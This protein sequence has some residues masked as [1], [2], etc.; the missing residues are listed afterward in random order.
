[1]A[2]FFKL[3]IGKLQINFAILFNVR[4]FFCYKSIFLIL[5]YLPHELIGQK[6]SDF[7]NKDDFEIAR[8]AVIKGKHKSKLDDCF[9]LIVIYLLATK[10]KEKIKSEPY[11]FRHK[12]GE[13][14]Y[15]ETHLSVFENPFNNKI[16]YV[17]LKCKLLSQNQE[18]IEQEQISNTEK[19]HNSSFV[20]TS[21][22]FDL[23]QAT[24]STDYSHDASASMDPFMMTDNNSKS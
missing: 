22:E 16:E 8:G 11:R 13:Y 2:L 19:A 6:I 9:F 20:F 17:I 21:D 5:G 23:L 1:M 18:N 4:L 14:L 24:P 15:V 10:S 7:I 3:I 12:S